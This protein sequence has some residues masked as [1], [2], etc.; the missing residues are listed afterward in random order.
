MWILLTAP[1]CFHMSQVKIRCADCFC[2]FFN[3]LCRS[4]LSWLSHLIRS[5]ESWIC[6]CTQKSFPATDC[7]ILPVPIRSS[8]YFKNNKLVS[9]CAQQVPYSSCIQASPSLRATVHLIKGWNFVF[10]TFCY[11]HKLRRC[12]RVTWFLSG[13]FCASAPP[14]C[15]QRAALDPQQCRAINPAS[16]ADGM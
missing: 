8:Y 3:A 12:S 16:S 11:L 15:P 7:T 2:F 4:V 5:D 1:S 9:I 13:F 6:I 10:F 14:D